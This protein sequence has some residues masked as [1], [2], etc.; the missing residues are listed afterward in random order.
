M[1]CTEPLTVT[2]LKS[3]I[4]EGSWTDA[5]LT[6]VLDGATDFLFSLL[7]HSFGRAIRIYHDES[8]EATAATVEVTGTGIVLT[9][10][11]GTHDGWTGTYLFA[12]YPDMVDM[13]DGIEQEDKGFV[14]T[15]V[16]GMSPTEATTNLHVVAVAGCL[17]LTNRQILCISH[18]TETMDGR[19]ESHIFTTLPLRS[20]TSIVQD[21]TTVTSSYYWDKQLGYVIYKY[22]VGSKYEWY[23]RDSWST[24]QPCNITIRYVPLWLRI[25]GV[26]KLMLKAM[27]QH[28]IVDG[29]MS[30][31][32]IG[33]YSY[34]LGDVWAAIA[35]FWMMISGYSVSFMP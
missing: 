18:I 31:E 35:P 30:S 3:L 19:G 15:L 14:A 10:T 23:V 22:C 12:D 29:S 13:V 6:I 24:K 11:G 2:E 20:V 17:G 5:A 34:V 33:D 27:C 16:E 9:I 8:E 21:G 26:M 4:D 1:K 25:P 28:T 7:G 32:T